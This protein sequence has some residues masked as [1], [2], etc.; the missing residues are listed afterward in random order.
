MRSY[1]V[2][3]VMGFYYL[4][5]KELVKNAWSRNWVSSWHRRGI[6]C[7]R[8]NNICPLFLLIL[9]PTVAFLSLNEQQ[10]H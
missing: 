10:N 6:R 9:T 5:F 7:K 3:F 2:I 4:Y 1:D 8:L